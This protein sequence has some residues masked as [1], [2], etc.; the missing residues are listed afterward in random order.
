MTQIRGEGLKRYPHLRFL[1]TGS[2]NS[3][4]SVICGIHAICGSVSPLA[5][6]LTPAL[7]LEPVRFGH[8]RTLLRESQIGVY[9]D[10]DQ[11]FEPDLWLPP[12]VL[13][14]LAGVSNQ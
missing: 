6:T 12:K 1:R 8:P 9:H 14:C 5:P 11:F 3:T 4:T 7:R 13:F 10:L 2:S